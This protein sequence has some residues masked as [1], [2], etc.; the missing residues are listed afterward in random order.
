MDDY[1]RANRNLWNEWAEI[2]AR[3]TTECYNLESFKAGASS[4]HSIELEEL[5]DVSG[6]SLLHLQ[7]HFGMDT[8]SWARQGAKV[9]GADFSDRAIAIA[10]SLSKEVGIEATFVCC[11]LY[12][13]PD[14]LSGQ[15]DIV[16]TSYGVLVWLPDITGWAE[17]IAHFLKPGGTF[18]IVEF[19]P[20]C[21]VFDN[22]DDV[23]GLQVANPYFH[24]AEP[25][26]FEV[27]GSYADREAKVEQPVEYEW[28]H[29]LGD[30]VNALIG[31]GLRIEFLH[32][33]PYAVDPAI[34]PP[35]ATV[36][37]E[38]GW[39][40]LADRDNMIPLMFSLKAT[41]QG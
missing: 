18:Y 24:S 40:R 27:S 26:E 33:F 15:F 29:S 3:S 28:M 38:E 6:R 17:V 8:L 31:A 37:D 12:D 16:F 41:K 22:G 14:M 30:I 10:R 39:Y 5:G 1:K 34:L 20:F 19:H 35:S 11:D 2:H 32:E 25:L 9:T 4:L 21:L 7:C 23:T 36:R 13:L